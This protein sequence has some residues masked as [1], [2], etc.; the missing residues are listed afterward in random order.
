MSIQ[1]PYGHLTATCRIRYDGFP[2]IKTPKLSQL[3]PGAQQS[4]KAKVAL[5]MLFYN[6]AVTRWKA[7]IQREGPSFQE[8]MR[9]FRTVQTKLAETCHAH[10]DH[11]ACVWYSLN[12]LQFFRMITHGRT[13]PVEFHFTDSAR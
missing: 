9:V 10:Q 11:P 6:E 2:F 12:D 5:D 7:L 1:P 4:V 13:M 8:E 3:S